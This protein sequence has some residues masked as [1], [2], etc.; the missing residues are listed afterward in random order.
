[1]PKTYRIGELAQALSVPAETIRYYEREGLLPHP[2][3]SQGNY[4]LYDEAQRR[5]LAF[6]LHCRALDMTQAEIRRLLDLRG[7]PEQGCDEVNQLLDA[8][9]GHVLTQIR[10]LRALQAELVAIRTR[11]ASPRATKD[12]EILKGLADPRSRPMRGEAAT[13]V[14]DR[15]RRGRAAKR[16]VSQ[17]G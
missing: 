7:M 13:A 11:C 8:H 5:Q 9:I 12:C 17:Q 14:H 1:M 2:A 4:R 16:S 6:V 15:G 3:R 10:S